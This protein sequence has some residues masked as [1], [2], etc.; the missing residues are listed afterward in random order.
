[1]VTIKNF[2]LTG[3]F[4]ADFSLKFLNCYHV[5]LHNVT[6]NT[7]LVG[8]NMMGESVLSDI[9]SDELDITYDDN[10]SV[11]LVNI[12]KLIICKYATA[13]RGPHVKVKQNLYKVSIII[14]NSIFSN[15]ITVFITSSCTTHHKNTVV[16]DKIYLLKSI[17]YYYCISIY[18][19]VHNYHHCSN[20]SIHKHDKVIIKSCSFIN[21]NLA[22]EI[23]HIKSLDTINETLQNVFIENCFFIG[24]YVD[25]IIHSEWFHKVKTT[26]QNIII[27]ECIFKDNL[28]RDGILSFYSHHTELSDVV[29]IINSKFV[30]NMC[31]GTYYPFTPTLPECSV[32]M[33][34]NIMVQLEG[35]IIVHNTLDF[36][37]V[38]KMYSTT[39]WRKILTGEIFD[40][41]ACG[42]F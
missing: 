20:K 37:F 32:I 18:F 6:M 33:T 39:V 1:M 11:E 9:I 12:H 8:H 24:N 16:F 5:Q 31:R 7:I 3:G 23:I 27:K 30:S 14:T 17:V 26:G 4:L 21:I 36:L 40:E 19:S 34:S 13:T 2:M 22:D 15:S 38:M 10:I 35:P 41:W 28:I 25:K 29:Y 42:K